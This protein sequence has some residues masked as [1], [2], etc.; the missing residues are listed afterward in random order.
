MATRRRRRTV[1]IGVT[2]AGIVLAAATGIVTRD[3]GGST[4]DA[5]DT[6]TATARR[7]DLSDLISASF[8]IGY[9]TTATLAAPGA[10]GTIT[11]SALAVGQAVPNLAPLVTIDRVPVFGLALGVPLYRP[12]AVGD[13]GPDVAGVELDLAAAGYDPGTVDEEFTADTAS[14]IR[15]F[16]SDQDVD[17]TGAIS[18][19]QFVGF[20]P[21][22]IVLTADAAVGARV[23]AGTALAA[24]GVP[25]SMVATASVS[26]SDFAGV[27]NGQ[28][29]DLALDAFPDE[30]VEGTVLGL[31]VQAAAGGGA[32]AGTSS[33]VQYDV[34][35]VPASLPAGTRAGMTGTAD[36]A[37][38]SRRDV[39]IVPA[40]AVGGTSSNPTVEVVE[41]G[42][43]V[44]RPVV[45][46]LT[47]TDGVEIV[48][49]L[50]PGTVVV[51]GT[52]QP[53]DTTATTAPGTT[54]FPGGG[55]VPGGGP[56]GPNVQF[57][58]G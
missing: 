47:T 3:G 18:L 22:A 4:A 46:G 56:S 38:R 39:V 51:V 9:G 49:G 40:S 58:P 29:V 53:Q 24:L 33:V 20:P 52:D 17:E 37:I 42:K 50:Q 11:T 27:Q 34:T 15:S 31:P 14:A 57:G 2:A 25:S 35:I 44:T 1:V 28:P 7:G 16:Q 45:V 32:A 13:S 5:A 26:E 10:G 41:G 54:G 36:I 48:T 12:L 19:D 43:H 6:V 23:G 8:T 30:T 55:R 21:G